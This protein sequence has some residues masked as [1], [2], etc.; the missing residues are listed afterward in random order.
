MQ[1]AIAR[2]W[3]RFCRTDAVIFSG[4]MPWEEAWCS[5][6]LKPGDHILLVGCGSGGDLLALLERGD[7]VDG[8]DPSRSAI[9]LARSVLLRRGFSTR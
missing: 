2:T 6:V 3:D 4:L 8:L 7:Q 1:R 5:R 9:D